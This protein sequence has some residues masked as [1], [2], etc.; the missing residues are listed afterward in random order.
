[1]LEKAPAKNRVAVALGAGGARG[2]AH[3]A[4]LEALD[5]LGVKPVAISGSSMGAIVGAA[6]ASGIAAADIRAHVL[7]LFRNKGQT[8]A[9]LMKARVG[10]FSDFFTRLDS[11]PIL[12]DAEL[13]LDMFW[14]A[15]MADTFEELEI[16][17][18]AVATNYHQRCMAPFDSGLL[19]PAVAGS[20][21]I[22]G[23]VKPVELDGLVL[24]DG[25][26]IDPLP[27]RSLIGKA[28]IVIACD[29]MGA[30]AT[31]QHKPPEPYA[32]LIGA[33]Q[34]VQFRI[35]EE[36]LKVNRPDLL[37]RPDVGRFKA[38][39]FFRAAQILEAAHNVKEELKRALHN[40]FE[41]A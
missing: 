39:D 7:G 35:T 16:P 6:Y 9:R 10:K 28:E 17:F 3:I 26:M 37:L 32:A 2:F 24:V 29:V 15:L 20:M 38:L 13:L 36:M 40:K 8:L 27:Y 19:A 5:E 31:N 34:I 11:N 14:P 22:P 12:V 1:M 25:G 18:I 4:V 33:A 23:I 41:S 30:A 21:A